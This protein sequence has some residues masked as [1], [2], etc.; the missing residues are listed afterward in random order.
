MSQRLP[1]IPN[2]DHLKKQA[3]DVLRV[4]RHRRQEWRLADAQHA[5]ARGYGFPNW[6][7]LKRHVEAIRPKARAAPADPRETKDSRNR[8]DHPIVGTWAAADP[9][10]GSAHPPD[11]GDVI[12]EFAFTNDALVLTQI[13]PDD[14]GS[15]VAMKTTI[16]VD[17]V[18][19]PVPF[20]DNVTLR[21]TWLD[22]QTLETLARRGEQMVWHATYEVSRDGRSLV[23]SSA[24]RVVRFARVAVE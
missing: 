17:G 8:Q 3:K 6:T 1:S 14:K 12:V 22:G 23:V 15:D 24:E 2:L 10:N 13:A 4:A 19:H 11:A 16:S 21:A 18:D 7:D 5:L 9:V 20:G